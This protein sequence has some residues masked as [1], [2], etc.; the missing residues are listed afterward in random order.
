MPPSRALLLTILLL[1]FALRLHHLGD[2]SLWYDETVSAY[3]AQQAPLDLIAHTARDIHPPG[4]YL[5][6]HFWT[7]LIGS[8][9]FALAYFSLCFGLLLIVQL[10]RVAIRLTDSITATW[11]ALFMA[12]SPFGVWYSQEVRMYTLGAW[13]G[14]WL[15]DCLSSHQVTRSHLMTKKYWLGYIIAAIIG[16]YTLYYFA[17]LLIALNLFI[18]LGHRAK[19]RPLIISNGL[20]VLAYLPW[21]PTLWR[22]VTQPPVPPWRSLEQWQPIPLEIGTALALGQSVETATVWP[23][24][25]LMW[26]I[27]GLGGWAQRAKIGFWLTYLFGPI[28][29]ILTLSW[30]TPL[31]H[32]RYIFIYSPPFY[33]I[34]A[35]GAAKITGGKSKDLDSAFRYFIL[36]SL[37]FLPAMY[38]L[39]QLHTNPRYQA[40]DYRG[41]VA[42]IQ[43]HWQ[44]GDV[45]MVNAGYLYTAFDYYNHLDNLQHTRLVPY[46]LSHHEQP[47]LVQT[48]SVN[49]SPQ[50]GWGLPEA[51]FYAMS[52]ADTRAALQHLAHDFPRLWLLRGYDTVTDPDGLIR[53]WLAENAIPLEDQPF[54]GESNIR[55]QGFLLQTQPPRLHE[56]ITF[57]DGLTLLD[58]SLPS[59]SWQAGQAIHLKL[60]WQ[61]GQKPTVDYKMSLK[62]W[63]PNGELAAQGED[64]WPAGSLYRTSA[65]RVG[66]PVYT[67]QTLTL[68]TDLPPGQYWLNVELYHPETA[69]PLPRLDGADPVVTL[70]AVEVESAK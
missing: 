11:A 24:V 8:S 20:I 38:S 46:T 69:I 28:L 36:L 16:L 50:L 51:D 26:L 62:L 25:L 55:V 60:W 3:L 22:Q 57:A 18:L 27:F 44:P 15:T 5:L 53:Q 6:L 29:L 47:I 45:I 33:L 39:Q 49:G 67:P 35:M 61:A 65:W 59:Q 23:I 2:Q 34:L 7:R 42:F 70:G 14:L 58:W 21:L 31:Y 43:S 4:Y 52:A 68:P 32:V 56:A 41:A 30:F 64:N 17:F 13:L 63:R 48:G 37:T 12:I 66:Q 54:A 40:D 9:E 19:V 10:Y 1:A